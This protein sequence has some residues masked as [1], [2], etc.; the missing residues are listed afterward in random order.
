[1][2]STMPWSRSQS[3]RAAAMRSACWGVSGPAASSAHMWT[4]MRRDVRGVRNSWA[5][6]AT[7]SFF[8]SSKRTS[9]VTSWRTIVTPVTAPSSE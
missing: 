8:S 5:T 4:A 1:M 7:R 3:W 6:V 9:R 2:S